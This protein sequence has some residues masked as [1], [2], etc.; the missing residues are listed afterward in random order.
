MLRGTVLV[1]TEQALGSGITVDTPVTENPAI[2]YLKRKTIGMLFSVS[3]TQILFVSFQC[4]VNSL[5]AASSPVA[6][7]RYKTK[8]RGA[9]IDGEE[10]IFLFFSFHSLPALRKKQI[11]R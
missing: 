3:S 11:C 8:S 2:K 1:W 9:G 7:A 10:R 6:R 5:K 4:I